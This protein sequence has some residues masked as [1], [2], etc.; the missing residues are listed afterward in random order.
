MAAAREGLEQLLWPERRDKDAKL[1]DKVPGRIERTTEVSR[2][3]I[4]AAMMA[5]ELAKVLSPTG[6]FG[7]PPRDV[8]I[9][10]I[11]AGTPVSLLA[12]L[13]LLDEKAQALLLRMSRDLKTEADFAKLV[14]PLFEL[15]ACPDYVVNRGH[16]FGTGMDGEKALSDAQK[17]DLIEFLRS[18]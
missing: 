18:L 5:P 17:K 1:G 15:S 8:E 4:P 6:W 7:G 11:P 16:Y 9:G 13:N 2:L 10:P 12:S 14:E 3:R